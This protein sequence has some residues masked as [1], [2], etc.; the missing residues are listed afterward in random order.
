M[1]G[2]WQRFAYV[3][4]SVSYYNDIVERWGVFE[5]IQP[6]PLAI[7]RQRDQSYRITRSGWHGA[8]STVERINGSEE[9]VQTPLAFD[10][11]WGTEFDDPADLTNTHLE[12]HYQYEYGK[13]GQVVAVTATDFT[14]HRIWRKAFHSLDRASYELFSSTDFEQQKGILGLLARSADQL[15][16]VPLKS[17]SHAKLVIYKW[18]SDGHKLAAVFVDEDERP[19]TNAAGIF[20]YSDHQD[21][22]GRVVRRTYLDSTGVP[23]RNVHG[24]AGERVDYA[25]NYICITSVDED[26]QPC[27][28]EHGISQQRIGLDAMGKWTSCRFFDSQLRLIIHQEGEHELVWGHDA[29]GNLTETKCIGPDGKI[30]S[31]VY[32]YAIARMTYDMRGRRKTFRYFDTK[33]QPI[34]IAGGNHGIDTE[35]DLRGNRISE[36]YVGVDGRPTAHRDGY[37]IVRMNYDDQG[38]LKSVRYFD[39]NEQR[40]QNRD[41]EHGYNAEYDVHGRRLLEAYIGVD[42]EPAI[43]REGYAL[44]RMAYDELGRQKSFRYFNAHDQ[45]TTNVHGYHGF[46]VVYNKYGHRQLERYF[47]LD[48]NPTSI[49]QGFAIARMKYDELGRQKSVRY[50][51]ADDHRTLHA[52]AYHGFDV[53]FDAR[54]NRIQKSYVGIEEQPVVNRQG[55]A[56]VRTEYDELGR[57]KSVRYFD[58]GRHRTTTKSG[59]NHGFDIKHDVRGNRCSE[60]AVGL[61]EQPTLMPQG[62]AISKTEFDEL[63]RE[64]SVRYF[65]VND[66]ATLIADGYHGLFI[67]YDPQGNRR[68]ETYVGIDKNPILNLAGYAIVRMTYD[69]R[70]HE[71]SF[72]YFD[73]KDQPAI[74]SD[75]YHGLILRCDVRGNR[76]SGKHIGVAENTVLHREG[77][78]IARMS[79]D[80]LGNQKSIRYF[81]AVDQR[82]THPDGYHGIDSDYDDHGNKLE[83][84]YVGVDQRPTVKKGRI[85]VTRWTYDVTGEQRSIRYFDLNQNELRPQ[86]LLLLQS[87]IAGGEAERVGLQAG[88][89]IL[90]Y[91]DIIEDGERI[92]ASLQAPTMEVRL[93]PMSILRDGKTLDF[94][95][96]PGLLGI[97]V[98]DFVRFI[99]LSKHSGEAEDSK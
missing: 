29:Q 84:R 35:Y 39:A 20:G 1:H 33:H 6:I 28:N 53:E 66:Q 24:C 38:R 16:T 48:D 51:D 76:L 44:A 60:K 22:L 54:G 9:L 26:G 68:S 90:S 34:T 56:M 69:D 3:W 83:E 50:F 46:D 89:I 27:L 75:G 61:D 42:E 19:Q 73:T 49:R 36:T 7:V 93:I 95:V 86:T 58:A 37:A 99:P 47:G 5:G 32:G 97:R 12:S 57:Q 79:Y 23:F 71:E 67:E 55:Y 87:I 41:G 96:K 91:Y 18:S 65:D 4:P 59:G 64:K 72:R 31:N 10:S 17:G 40:T 52:D 82:T 92:L 11:Q 2:F 98:E 94:Q 43:S 30:A 77:Y 88:D 45:R 62:F 14:G 15:D 81:D 8:V 85:A 63:G 25:T 80:E 74:V 13:S 21:Y 70:G 78:A